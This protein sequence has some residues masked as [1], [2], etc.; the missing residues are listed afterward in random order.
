MERTADAPLELGEVGQKREVTSEGVAAHE[1]RRLT[2][3]VIEILGMAPE[4]GNVARYQLVRCTVADQLSGPR[5]GFFDRSLDPCGIPVDVHGQPVAPLAP[6]RPY[7]QALGQLALNPA[8]MQYERRHLL[9]RCVQAGRAD[10]LVAS[11][12]SA[13]RHAC[14]A[15]SQTR[16][17]LGMFASH[18]TK[19]ATA[20]KRC[21]ARAYNHHTASLTGAALCLVEQ[22]RAHVGEAGEVNL[23]HSSRRDRVHGAQE[24]EAK[25][26]A[27]DVHI[28]DV[29]QDAAVGLLSD[30][31]KK[32]PLRNIRLP[33]RNEGR[34]VL[35]YYLTIQLIL[36]GPYAL[37]DM[38]QRFF[39]IGQ[40][41]QVVEAAA[42]APVQHG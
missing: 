23:R 22:I 9:L 35:Q 15:S 14:A 3:Q 12:S 31:R 33:V 28:V 40:R 27:A 25:V 6:R 1:L 4:R 7:E 36:Y 37:R 30:R 11:M 5:K 38:R 8:G 34:G 26:V 29:E 2:A 21:T 13:M 16:A 24:I 19:V 32:L 17:K 42:A 41:Q 20:P 10:R 18:S 39:G